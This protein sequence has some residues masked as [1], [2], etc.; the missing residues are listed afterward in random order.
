[1]TAVSKEQT[2]A[3]L[4]QLGAVFHAALTDAFSELVTERG[5][6]IYRWPIP[7]RCS[8][9]CGRPIRAGEPFGQTSKD[10][11]PLER[12][13]AACLA[14]RKGSDRDRDEAAA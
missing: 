5:A 8:A 6:E 10:W 7:F 4:D 1:L 14:G 3:R 12:A 11:R 9:A 13:H 2:E